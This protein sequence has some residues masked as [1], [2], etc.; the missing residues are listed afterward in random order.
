MKVNFFVLYDG[1]EADGPVPHILNA[2]RYQTNDGAEYDSWLLL[3]PLAE[4]DTAGEV[5]ALE[6]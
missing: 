3:E 2:G 1:E 5:P 4:G 6:Q